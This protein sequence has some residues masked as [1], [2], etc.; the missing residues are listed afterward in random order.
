MVFGEPILLGQ[1]RYDNFAEALD[2]TTIYA[3]S[4]SRLEQYLLSTPRT[5]A[6]VAEILGRRLVEMECIGRHATVIALTRE[7]IATLAGTSRETTTKVLG[8]LTERGLIPA[9]PGPDHRPRP[10]RDHRGERRL[11]TRTI[12]RYFSIL[13]FIS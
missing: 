12:I 3:L 2:E 10:G 11:T 4:R 5:A 7:Q 9:E 8:D 13:R 1:Q 6:R